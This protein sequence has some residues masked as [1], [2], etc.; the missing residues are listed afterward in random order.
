[1]IRIRFASL[2]GTKQS[3][4]IIFGYRGT[5]LWLHSQKQF[6]NLSL[7]KL[8]HRPIRPLGDETFDDLDGFVGFLVNDGFF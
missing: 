3:K 1:M 6:Q 4:T 5:F 7:I 2:R 8:I